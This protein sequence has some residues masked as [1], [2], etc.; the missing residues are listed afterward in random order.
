MKLLITLILTMIF[1]AQITSLSQD[2]N[3]GK[4]V[5]YENTFW[6]EIE[7]SSNEFNNPEKPKKK[8]FIMDYSGIELPLSKEEFKSQWHTEPISQGWTGTCWCF[9]TTSFFE[10]ELKRRNGIELKLS[11][12]YTVY[13]E[14]IEKAIGFVDS[15]GSTH[16]G[17]GSLMNSVIQKWEK[18]GCMPAEF[19]TGL[20]DGR[21]YHDHHTLFDDFRTY[22][23]SIKKN[24]NWNKNQVVETVKA[25]LDQYIGTPP[26]KFTYKGKEYTPIS[27][28]R[29][30][31]NFKQEEY[32][33]ILSLF[34]SPY[35]DKCEY[36]V[37]D[38]WWNGDNYY[39]IPLDEYMNTIKKAIKMGYTM[40]IGGDVSES[41]YSALDDAAMVPSYD[42]PSEYIDQYARQ[43]RF[44]NKTTTDDH[45]IHLVGYKEQGNGMWFLIKDSGSGS[46]N[47]K[48]KGY[49]YY[50]EDYIKLKIM[51]F[52]VHKDA[53]K[54]ILKKFK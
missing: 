1:F 51:N 42:I 50:H 48:A 23:N 11:E 6:K 43:F 44:S 8:S 35:W 36:D 49:Y 9:A 41:G 37:P 18:Y 21:K 27:F 28:Y 33:D 19:F 20:K 4:F 7:K 29:D 13:W 16:L 34:E 39:N 32:I 54:D 40:V 5:E 24:K 31:V 15:R 47:G 38:N 10:S 45:A 53:V 46:R 52:I 17:E 12:L 22:L 26:T 30:V 2:K 14:Y 25:I 3:T